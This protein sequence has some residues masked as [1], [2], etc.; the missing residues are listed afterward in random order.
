MR[1]LF[2]K[3][4]FLVGFVVGSQATMAQCLGVF[5][6]S[7]VT[8]SLDSGSC[9]ST[10]NYTIPGGYDMCTSDTFTYNYTG[11]IERFEVPAGI[12]SITLRAWGASGGNSTW[13][14]F[15]SGGLGAYTS[16]TF[17]V[18]PGQVLHFIVGQQGESAAV[19]GGGGGTFV[20]DSASQMP[21]L[22]AGGGGG[23]SSDMNGVNAVITQDGTMD[24]LN[25]IAGGIA[26]NGGQ[27]CS[28]LDNNNGGGGGGFYSNGVSANS[29]VAG[30]S[31]G[32]F[33]GQSFLNGGAGG[34]PGRLDGACTG[35]AYGGFG[36]GGST[37][38]NTVGGAGGGGYSGGAGGLHL[39]NCGAATRSGGG[40]GGSFNSG[41]SP[42]NQVAANTGNGMLEISYF[43]TVGVTSTLISGLGSGATFPIG[44]TT[45]TYVIAFGMES[46]TCSLVVT[47]NDTI[48]PAF[49]GSI[50]DST[51]CGS[52][53]GIAPPAVIDNCAHTITY[54]LTG[55]TT[56]NG[57]GDAGAASFN[58]GVTT[59]EY[60]VTDEDGN[61]DVLSF[62]VT[63]NPLPIIVAQGDTAVCDEMG[64]LTLNATP[65]GGTWSG[66]GVTGSTFDPSVA[67]IGSHAISYTAMTAEGCSDTWTATMDVFGCASVDELNGF[68]LSLYPNPT[69]GAVTLELGKLLD[70]V[71]VTVVDLNG[72][73]VLN[74]N[75]DQLSKADLNVAGLPTGVF[76][77]K[78]SAENIQKTIKLIKE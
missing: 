58:T 20:V 43:S 4:L 57:T 56:G 65:A 36:G 26:G 33:G 73:V 71:E 70:Q 42:V 10:V 59:V 46:D 18:T 17:A 62:D 22:I 41:T 66:T 51:Y 28:T 39:S 15:R 45:E 29:N 53:T 74:E 1:T 35:D 9:T 31:N 24:A 52:P 55:A 8:T 37:S 69:S 21:L 38:C 68:T 49:A 50:L 64:I 34:A 14:T 61:T 32:G 27:A 47:V 16:G 77:V 2:T 67:G 3:F 6:A 75:Y 25:I 72:R 11:A 63:V 60:T 13:S 5:C 7:D 76:F 30:V 48:A 19:G 78:V 23:A 44:S 40:G 12:N 54:A